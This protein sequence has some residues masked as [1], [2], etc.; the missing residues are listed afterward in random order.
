MAISDFT[1]FA[2]STPPKPAAPSPFT[3]SVAES[4][5]RQP[6]RGVPTPERLKEQ[7]LTIQSAER[8]PISDFFKSHTPKVV[9]D[10]FNIYKEALF[11]SGQGV[12]L[13][14]KETMST[15][16]MGF[17][18]PLGIGKTDMERYTERADRLIAS[19][20][21]RERAGEIA[22]FYTKGTGGVDLMEK[23]KR[24]DA[25]KA[26][27][28]ALNLTKKEKSE[29]G[30]VDMFEK[31]DTAL[32]A[33]DA[34]S[35]GSTKMAR[36]ALGRIAKSEV[37]SEISKILS[38]EI[39][40]LSKDKSALEGLS[41]ILSK[42]RDEKQVE[43]VINRVEFHY[44]GAGKSTAAATDTS[45]SAAIA[46]GL[47]EDEFVKGQMKSTKIF[48]RQ[49]EIGDGVNLA[50]RSELPFASNDIN[51]ALGQGSGLDGAI[52]KI[53]GDVNYVGSAPNYQLGGLEKRHTE[54]V[55][56]KKSQLESGIV[57]SKLEANGYDLAGAKQ[58]TDVG[59]TR[60]AKD[61]VEIQNTNHVPI[62]GGKTTAELRAEYQAAKGESPNTTPTPSATPDATPLTDAVDPLV[63]GQMR[64]TRGLELL[65]QTGAPPKPETIDR[66][67][68]GE[69]T[70]GDGVSRTFDEIAEDAMITSNE[71]ALTARTVKAMR[72]M[73]TNVMEYF[74]DTEKRIME[75]QRDPNIRF[76]DESDIYQTITLMPGR[77]GDVAEKGRDQVKDIFS[78][79]NK[80][81]KGS[82]VGFRKV[83]DDVNDFLWLRHAPERNVALG[84]GAAGIS[85][86]DA[87]ERLAKL[88]ESPYFDEVVRLGEEITSMNKAAL[89][90][91]LDSGVIDAK[92]YGEL[93]ERYEYYTPLNRVFEHTSDIKEGLSGRGFDV[94]STGIRRAKGSSR[95]VADIVENTMLNFEQAMIRSE[96]NIVDRATLEFV[97]EN[98]EVLK[99]T[100][101]I[102]YPAAGESTDDPHIL[103]LYDKGK[104]VWI[105]I[106]DGDLAIAMRGVG[107]EKLPGVMYPLAAYSR[108]LSGLL[109]RFSPE[110]AIPNI[111]RDIQER[112]VYL[113]AQKGLGG[114]A[115]VKAIARD[116]KSIAGIVDHLRGKETPDALLYAEMKSL[117]GTTGGL[118]LSTRKKTELNIRHLESAAQ[119]SPRAYGE[120]LLEYVDNWNTVFEDAT[121]LTTYK[122]A[123]AEGMTKKQA[124]FQAK[125]AT[126]NFNR[127]G[128][129]GPVVNAMYMFANASIQGSVKTL[130]AMRNPKVLAGLTLTIGTAVTA[131]NEWNESVDPNWRNNV[132]KWDLVNG[133]PIMIPSD[134]GSKRW[135]T[136][137]VS[138]G[139]K[140]IRVAADYIYRFTNEENVTVKEM[141][142]GIASAA[143]ESYNPVGGVDLMSS[144]MPTVF[145]MPFDIARNKSWAGFQIKPNLD[146][147]APE[148]IK[149]FNS[150]EEKSTGKV[151]IS[152]T[153]KLAGWG[154]ELSPA[155]IVY[156][157]ETLTGG[158]GK[159]T[160]KLSTSI[161]SGMKGEVP[162]MSEFPFISRFYREKQ[163][164]EIFSNSED[165]NFKELMGQN[166]KDSFYEKKKATEIW[167]QMAEL[168]GEEKMAKLKELSVSNEDLFD[169]VLDI[170]EAEKLGLVG[171]ERQ[172]KTSPTKVRAQYI[173][174]KLSKLK[175]PEEKRALLLDYGEK[176]IIT[177][178]VV[179]E[180]EILLSQ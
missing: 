168:S 112:T 26:G 100:M 117:G 76:G 2:T 18:R 176:K 59:A 102:R 123:L 49:T 105:E 160:G 69:Y 153:Q 131:A 149:Y 118:G 17:L 120:K 1:R 143:I 150:L 44:R 180:L 54:S 89:K 108:F 35:V 11:G 141:A 178:A 177:D 57:R 162:A 72:S 13:A 90:A 157:F 15:G 147:Y 67:F 21:D 142:E 61:Y 71:P 37:A 22:S 36:T 7:N 172:L 4:F 165:S 122:Q 174:A 127:M 88:S 40:E 137:P 138:Y 94:R 64:M 51:L 34:V 136:I 115:A 106:A 81:A 25:S 92:F 93:A 79:M 66:A 156:A 98:K 53:T 173:Y 86:K 78:S 169:K 80:L 124:A 116:P 146:P 144:L 119:G 29:L 30:Y 101:K 3:Q 145:D 161:Q 154:V 14:G 5:S 47:T 104:K 97:K 65:D 166:R 114:K 175:T 139:I 95:E 163:E 45:A 62:D 83:R 85:T 125:E 32:G 158:P 74:Q 33:L 8:N 48:Y 38:K 60:N 170:A 73:S 12:D 82:G 87:V 77:L 84:D 110:F 52:F 9:R 148:S 91:L 134:D 50:R 167:D 20:T 55:F 56:I 121:R 46:K 16:L 41:E 103:Q 63:S 135:V 99:D 130:R 43:S 23:M 27:I 58:A 129:A 42:V 128:K 10:G 24:D 126:V 111:I 96:K 6:L 159:F 152:L 75:L 31:L 132:S 28:A 68:R 113:A 19:G 179:D 171:E 107:K 39:P 70:A 133:L 109:T 140:P 155:D 151:A 164:D